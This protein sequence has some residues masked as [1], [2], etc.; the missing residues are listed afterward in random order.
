MSSPVAELDIM[1]GST[2]F[3]TTTVNSY[4]SSISSGS[5]DSSLQEL[6]KTIHN[7]ITDSVVILIFIFLNPHAFFG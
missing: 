1:D 3:P 5:V 2:K 6:I 7:I 4:S